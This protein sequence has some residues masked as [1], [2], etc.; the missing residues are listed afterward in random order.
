MKTANTIEMGETAD[1]TYAE[2][3]QTNKKQI[4]PETEK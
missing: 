1:S 4:R 3:A 2:T